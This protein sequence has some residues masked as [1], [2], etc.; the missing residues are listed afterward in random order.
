[1]LFFNYQSKEKKM[2]D[3]EFFPTPKELI[4][5][6]LSPYFR[7]KFLTKMTVLEPSAG[8][9]DIADFIQEHMNGSNYYNRKST[10]GIFCLERNHDLQAILR[11]KGYRVIG[12]DFLQFSGVGYLFDLII[13]NPPFSNGAQHLIHAWEIMQSGNIV[14]ILPKETIKNK[15]SKERELLSSI[16]NENDGVIEK[17]GSA[18]KTAEHKTGVE[19]C[20]VR[21]KKHNESYIENIFDSKSFTRAKLFE[22]ETPLTN[23][24]QIA[25]RN[26]I[27]RMVDSY[28]ATINSFSSTVKAMRELQY[29]GREFG[30]C[31]A[32]SD[33][34]GN[35]GFRDVVEAFCDV[36]KDGFSGITDKEK[37]KDEYRE[38][39]N[40]FSNRVREAAWK[41]VF[42]KT[43]VSKFMT[44]GVRHEFEK[45]Q[46]DNQCIEFTEE[47]I[48]KLLE[49]LLLSGDGIR[50]AAII[51]AFD[52]M[53][54]YHKENR[55][56]WEGWKTNDIWR[57]NR[58]FILPYVLDSRW[59]KPWHICYTRE[60][61][62]NDIDRGL[63]M[64]EGI[65]YDDIITITM[66]I[67]KAHIEERNYGE[68]IQSHFFDIRGYK[69]ETGHFFFKD[70]NVWENF[71]VAACKGKKWLPG[72]VS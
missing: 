6:M 64:L 33:S 56:H 22:S 17:V 68:K 67:K 47:N 7:D 9:G 50:E 45:M 52:L 71:N 14:C 59:G 19:V 18:F 61:E 10:D 15:Y 55:I 41:T 28:R 48:M 3:K 26:I 29:Y 43:E 60:Q 63:C 21:L 35:S 53:T 20:I 40:D 27:K 69:K 66:A 31:Y 37:F 65:C 39:Y 2:F 5:K 11:E 57:V 25:R 32:A 72:N 58:K 49:T 13:M 62:L 34:R 1:M 38:R 24:N 4:K 23:E 36:T 46:K 54:K 8:K 30:S 51:E 16:I 70:K 42:D 12:E 44:K